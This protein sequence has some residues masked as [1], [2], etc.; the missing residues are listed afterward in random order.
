MAII[1]ISRGSFSGG[2]MLAEQLGRRLECPCI[3]RDALVRRAAT[4]RVSEWD[5]RAALEQPPD[6]PGAF[7][8][9]RYTYLALIQAALAEQVRTG[10]AVYHGLAGHL[11]LKGAPGLMRVRLIAPFEFRIAMARQRLN[12][13]RNEAIGHIE[14][15][16]R[17]RR[18]WTQF[19]YG[20]DWGDPAQYDVVINL[21]QLSVEQA[22]RLIVSAIEPGGLE[23]SVERRAALYDFAMA[24]R[25]RAE[26]A[27]DLETLNLEV[28]VECR[29]GSISIRCDSGGEEAES[30][31]R[32][33]SAIPGVTEVTLQ[34]MLEPQRPGKNVPTGGE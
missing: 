20:V 16:D 29:G 1:T 19:L 23:F 7:N 17:D 8:H 27:R 6:F 9:R 32:V 18:R 12:L 30:I 22:C 4:G 15:M 2:K 34:E 28:E 21:E 10:R 13:S 33:V 25:V 5:L 3:D 14:A 24:S 26:L 11:L 31:R